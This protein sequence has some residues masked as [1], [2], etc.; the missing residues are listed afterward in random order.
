MMKIVLFQG[1]NFFNK[2]NSFDKELIYLSEMNM[3]NLIMTKFC[4][5]IKHYPEN[6]LYQQQII[7]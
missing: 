4:T 7:F 6:N 1:E 2:N 5:T 3:R